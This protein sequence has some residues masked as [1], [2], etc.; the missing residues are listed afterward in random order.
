MRAVPGGVGYP[1]RYECT[2]WALEVLKG[3]SRRIACS[4]L[5]V[6][7]CGGACSEASGAIA[8]PASRP[9]RL[10]DAF[11][12][13]RLRLSHARASSASTAVSAPR[14]S[15]RSQ[16]RARASGRHTSGRPQG[17]AW[18]ATAVTHASEWSVSGWNINTLSV[19]CF[20]HDSSSSLTAGR[21]ARNSGP[22]SAVEYIVAHGYLEL[23]MEGS[24]GRRGHTSARVH[25]TDGEAKS[26]SGRGHTAGSSRAFQSV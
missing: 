7:G 3:Y 25:S 21:A 14:G 10:C 1:R 15:A 12:T 19:R 23:P 18:R 5:C 13:K 8:T 17:K 16:L 22:S 6:F 24:H 2:R 9:M 4:C 11:S 26:A 20:S